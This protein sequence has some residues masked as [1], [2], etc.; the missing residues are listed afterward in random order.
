MLTALPLSP[1]CRQAEAALRRHPYLALR[2]LAC[3]EDAEGAL[4][5]RGCVTCYYLKQIAQTT[6]ARLPGV[7][8]IANE[9]EVIPD[10]PVIRADA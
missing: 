2:R 4:V 6:V 7:T 1:L 10:R 9:I 3:E 8:S 5:L